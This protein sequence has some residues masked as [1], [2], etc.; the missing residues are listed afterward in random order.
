[1]SSNMTHAKMHPLNRELI[2]VSSQCIHNASI[3]F[4]FGTHRGQSFM[5]TLKTT[6][7]S[8]ATSACWVHNQQS[9][10]FQVDHARVHPI[11]KTLKVS[12]T[13]W[14]AG[15]NLQSRKW[16]SGCIY[17]ELM[18]AVKQHF[19]YITLLK[20]KVHVVNVQ[21]PE[22]GNIFPPNTVIC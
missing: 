15:R 12:K 14:N 11:A 20:N 10:L 6:K 9:A 8:M 18:Y 22:V 4:L 1:M 5:P 16:P 17:S 13:L 7:C 21:I 3:F 19:S 2:N